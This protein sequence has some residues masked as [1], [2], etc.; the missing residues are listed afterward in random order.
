MAKK[1]KRFLTPSRVKAFAAYL[2]IGCLAGAVILTIFP[3]LLGESFTGSCGNHE[4][5]FSKFKGVKKGMK[6]ADR[7]VEDMRSCDIA[8][9]ISEK[10]T[11]S[12]RDLQKFDRGVKACTRLGKQMP[13]EL[14]EE[15]R[16]KS[17]N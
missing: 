13:P 14:V 16:N 4:E 12:L 10:N 3:G 8:R 6:K 17:K 11:I 1:T 9:R 2:I 5:S 7:T 15:V